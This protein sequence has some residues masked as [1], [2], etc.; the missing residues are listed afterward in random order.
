MLNEVPSRTWLS[1]ASDTLIRMDE[2]EVEMWRAL[3]N[4]ERVAEASIRGEMKRLKGLKLMTQ[5]RTFAP[6]ADVHRN[7]AEAYERDLRE[8]D[9]DI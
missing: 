2:A 7:A 5:A 9:L 3:A 6:L 4:D 1:D 8:A